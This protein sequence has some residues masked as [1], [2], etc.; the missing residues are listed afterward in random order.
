M[1]WLVSERLS[2]DAPK[3]HL[4]GKIQLN[5]LTLLLYA[6]TSLSEL[7]KA[8]QIYPEGN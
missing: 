3:L 1:I 5:Y 7:Y 8:A 2:Q 4:I 6:S